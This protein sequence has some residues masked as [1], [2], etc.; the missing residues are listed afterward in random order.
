MR[1][2][3]GSV[4]EFLESLES[5]TEIFDQ[6]IRLSVLKNPAVGREDVITDVVIQYGVLAFAG[7]LGY[8]LDGAQDCGRDYTDAEQ[9][10]QGTAEAERCKK[11]ITEFATRRGWR[12]LPGVLSE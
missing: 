11:K 1:V 9:D 2:V 12:V 8:L 7:E 10:F 5:V 3:V 4:D 6:T